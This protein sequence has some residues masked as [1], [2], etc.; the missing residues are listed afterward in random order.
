MPISDGVFDCIF[1]S[2][3]WHHIEDKQATADEC[4]RMLRQAG[5]TVIRTTSHDQL[6]KKIVFEYFPEIKDNQ[7]KVYPSNED[8]ESYFKKAGFSETRFY[9]Y[10][11]EQYQ[12]VEELVDI[13]NIKLWSMF[14]P[15]SDKGLEKGV[16]KLWKYYRDTGGSEI[17]FIRKWCLLGCFFG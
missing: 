11:L 16:E 12:S 14:R 3:V 8:F 7:I 15:I 17:Q 5:Y 13:A 1:S 6:N 9:E 10:S 2:Q 4:N